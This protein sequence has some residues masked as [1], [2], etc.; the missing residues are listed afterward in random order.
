MKTSLLPAL[1]AAA[2]LS[3][4]VAMH[5]EPAV[6][7][8][9][10]N[11]IAYLRG[12]LNRQQARIASLEAQI[13]QIGASAAQ[14]RYQRES[15]STLYASAAQTSALQ[16]QV[17]ELQKQIRALDAARATDRTQLLDD[18]S[19]KVTTIVKTS[20]P[21]PPKSK[22]VSNTGIE[23]VVQPGESLS[24]IAAAYGVSMKVIAEVNNIANPANIRIGQ[25]LF[26]PDP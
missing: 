24:K 10:Q 9:T 6:P 21:P 17:A 12:E 2:L 15:A 13:D 3:G 5:D 11:D 4:C 26:I 8:A 23:H 25:K 1:A 20:T 19:K 16:N 18:I 22:P 14:D 7:V